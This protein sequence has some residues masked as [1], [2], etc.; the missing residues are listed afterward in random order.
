MKSSGRPVLDDGERV[1][2]LNSPLSGRQRI[3]DH[4]NSSDGSAS[5][6]S[7]SVA[8]EPDLTPV[9]ADC[10]IADCSDRESRRELSADPSQVTLGHGLRKTAV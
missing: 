3:S 8:D 5:I 10:M 7:P 4:D 2:R 9:F 6:F 1:T